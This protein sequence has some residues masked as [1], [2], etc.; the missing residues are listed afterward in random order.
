[1]MENKTHPNDHLLMK[2]GSIFLFIGIIPIFIIFYFNNMSDSD[3][4]I[5]IYE[6]I[7]N[8]PSTYAST[9]PIISKLSFF[10]CK[11]SPLIALLFFIFCYKKLAIVNTISLNKLIINIIIPCLVLT[12]ISL[13]VLY[14]HNTDISDSGWK[15]LKS[16]SNS[17]HLLFSY[18]VLIFLGYYVWLFI[19]LIACIYFPFNLK[20]DN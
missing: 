15:I 3:T 9:H 18:Y 1:M 4:L 14:F 7:K 13:Y 17:K 5:I 19:F 16:I 8:T 6:K 12:T 11:L 20:T 2:W 10:Y